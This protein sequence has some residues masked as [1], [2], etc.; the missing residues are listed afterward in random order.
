MPTYTAEFHTDAEWALLDIKAATPEKALQKAR[1]IDPDTLDFEPYGDRQPVNYITI[2]DDECNDLA[3]WQ[4]DKLRLELA[5][6]ELLEALEFCLQEM[7]SV[8]VNRKFLFEAE[9]KARAAITKARGG[10]A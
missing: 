3:E 4:D 1:A 5:A 6:R 8:S 10:A 2:R 7:K 9:K